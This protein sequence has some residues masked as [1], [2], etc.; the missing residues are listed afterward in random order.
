MR[1]IHPSV[2]LHT[3]H[4]T[5]TILSRPTS[6]R[7][8]EPA[9]AIIDAVLD[10]LVT[11]AC[12]AGPDEPSQNLQPQPAPDSCVLPLAAASPVASTAASTESLADCETPALEGEC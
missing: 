7:L 5:P 6:R 10:A 2:A 12:A 11:A 8:A 4:C 9:H 1:S 3:R